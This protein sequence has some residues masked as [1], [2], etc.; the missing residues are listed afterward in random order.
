MFTTRLEDGET[1]GGGGEGGETGDEEGEEVRVDA[2]SV[3]GRSAES[4]VAEMP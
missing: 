3:F 4:Q 1:E 2:W